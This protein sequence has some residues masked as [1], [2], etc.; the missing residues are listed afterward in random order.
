MRGPGNGSPPG[1]GRFAGR[2]AHAMVDDPA[3]YAGRPGRA[4]DQ[5][6]YGRRAGSSFGPPS[7]AQA[8]LTVL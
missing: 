4:G 3:R 6:R 5:P 8:W 7:A 1:P 2:V